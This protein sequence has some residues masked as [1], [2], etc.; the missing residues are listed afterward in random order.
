MSCIGD[1]YNNF[2]DLRNNLI[3]KYNPDSIL[4]SGSATN[5]ASFDCLGPAQDIDL[6]VLAESSKSREIYQLRENYVET[7]INSTKFIGEC[8]ESGHVRIISMFRKARPVYDPRDVGLD[9]IKL[10]K[11]KDLRLTETQIYSFVGE[12]HNLVQRILEDMEGVDSCS[13]LYMAQWLFDKVANVLA[14]QQNDAD[15]DQPKIKMGWVRALE[16]SQDSSLREFSKLFYSVRLNESCNPRLAV[17]R[18]EKIIS[19]VLNR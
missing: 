12:K 5:L 14:L 8:I 16:D 7:L 3:D 1:K 15:A 19:D 6:Y 10:S 4:I 18:L 11:N 13:Q 2:E 17:E 9:M